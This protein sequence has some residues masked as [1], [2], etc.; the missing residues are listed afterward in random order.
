MPLND[1]DTSLI[2]VGSPV[3]GGCCYT[4]FADSPKLPTDATTKMGTLADFESLG[5]LSE[6]GYTESKSVTSN[7]FKGWHGSVVLTKISDEENTFKVEFLEINRPS[8]AKLRYGAANVETG[9]D[10]SVSHI[11]AVVGTET[12]VPLVFDELESNGCLRRTLVKRA[13]IDSFDDVPHAQGSLM[14][15]G[16]TFTAVDTGD[17]TPIEIFRAKPAASGASTAGAAVVDE[18]KVGE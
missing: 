1:I 5:E 4:S 8:V 10:G 18:S 15:Y 13:T 11:K 2:T 6:N 14:V 16:M 17:G 7:K 9:D 3:E 12:K